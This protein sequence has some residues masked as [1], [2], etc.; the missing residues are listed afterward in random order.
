M[1]SRDRRTVARGVAA[2][3]AVAGLLSVGA[4]VDSAAPAAAD[5]PPPPVDPGVE[6]PPENLDDALAPSLFTLLG[7][8]APT[9]SGA[10]VDLF[11][12][13]HSIPSV[14][15]SQPV[16][17]MDLNTAISS[18]APLLPQQFK[19]AAPDE[20]NMYSIG[21][22]DVTDHPELI[23]ALKGA[24]AI[25]HGGMGR[26]T[27]DQLGE[28]LPGTAPPPG[29]NIPPGVVDYL[30]DPPPWPQAPVP[31]PAPPLGG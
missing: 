3:I 7:A 18:G 30:P 19:L 28:P 21:Q 29:T 10:P 2:K 20:G 5:P 11:L 14:P 26:L 15:G 22:G 8:P 1:K 16:P 27:P 25:W 23:P 31:P 24:H 17:P 9:G 6:P 4:G 12:G 13:Q